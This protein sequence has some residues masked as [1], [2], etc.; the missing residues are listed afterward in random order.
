MDDPVPVSTLSDILK[1]RMNFE[2]SN[3]VELLGKIITVSN[4][5]PCPSQCRK[6]VHSLLADKLQKKGGHLKIWTR[7][8]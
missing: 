5:T 2:V 4:T 6:L 1:E 8:F 3:V 7:V